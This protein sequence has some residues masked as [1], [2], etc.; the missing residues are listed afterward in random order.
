MRHTGARPRRSAGARAPCWR[1][2]GVGVRR[3][4]HVHTS[5]ASAMHPRHRARRDTLAAQARDARRT[6]C[7]GSVARALGAV[8]Q[9][10]AAEA[11]LAGCGC[12]NPSHPAVPAT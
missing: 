6:A 5:H 3:S 4:A 8:R 1:W 7:R 9:G 2:R 10:R 12:Q 11:T